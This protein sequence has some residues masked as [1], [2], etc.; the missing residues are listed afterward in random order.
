MIRLDNRH[1]VITGAAGG[2]GQALVAAFGAAGAIVTGCDRPGTPI[3]GVTRAHGFDLADLAAV[4]AAA[5]DILARGIPDIVILNAGWT[6]QDTLDTTTSDG[7]TDELAANFTGTAELTRALV[8]AMRGGQRALVFIAS[9]N[10][11]T[12]HGNPAYSAA[13]AALLAW[14]RAIAVEEGLHGIRSNAVVPASVRTPVWDDRLRAD[15]Q[16]LAK[17]T[18]LYP[19]GRLVTVEE[20]ADAVL[21]LAS[22]L[23]SGI[24][25]A[26]LNV[27][28]GLTAGNL[29]FL[30]A[31]R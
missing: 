22:P 25:G 5:A 27:D 9:V 23:A 26:T 13:K 30:D 31:I 11:L 18:A 21:F 28:A 1:V 16:V 19:L 8:P 14:S 10:A 17:V 24:T 2:I 4:R 20:V 6:R 7:L 15:P 29:P 3:P 12:H